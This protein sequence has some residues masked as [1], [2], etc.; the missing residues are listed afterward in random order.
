MPG[1]EDSAPVFSEHKGT[2]SVVLSTLNI[3]ESSGKDREDPSEHSDLA[4]QDTIMESNSSLPIE[5][6]SLSRFINSATPSVADRCEEDP[7]ETINSK[8][9]SIAEP[10]EEVLFRSIQFT[11]PLHVD[12]NEKVLL[13]SKVN[14]HHE[15]SAKETPGPSSSEPY[16]SPRELRPIPTPCVPISTRKRKI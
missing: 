4:V 13:K 10:N 15:S 9:P 11:P 1:L 6:V 3:A 12:P 7:L 16:F 14:E 5:T 8:S 2:A